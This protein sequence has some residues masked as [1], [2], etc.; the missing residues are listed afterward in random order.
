MTQVP[1]T[2]NGF[3][4]PSVPRLNRK[5]P[6]S[7]PTS[8]RPLS[9][10]SKTPRKAW[11]LPRSRPVC[12][13]AS[14]SSA[15]PPTASSAGR[16]GD[17]HGEAARVRSFLL[18]RAAAMA[19]PGSLKHL[20]KAILACV[21]QPVLP[22]PENVVDA[23][24][25]YIDEHDDVALDRLQDELSAIFEKH[26]K[27]N[28]AA[29]APWIAA[30]RRLLPVLP[31]S[32]R[33][34]SWFDGCNGLLDRTEIDKTV[35]NEVIAALIDLVALIEKHQPNSEADLATKP[36]TDAL[37][38]VSITRLY[39]ALTQGDTSYEYNDKI[40]RRALKSFGKKKP[41]DFFTSVDAYFV[42]KQHRHASLRLLCDFIHDKPPHLHQVLHTSIFSNL[43]TCLQHD[44]STAVVSSALTVLIM[45]LPHMPSSLV[46]HLPTL[47]NVYARLLFWDREMSAAA[48]A[49]PDDAEEPSR[50]WQVCAYDAEI[51]DFSVP[52]LSNYYTILYGLYPINFMDYIRKPQRYLRH[53]N[54]SNPDDIEVQPT[55]IRHRSERFRRCH[56][57]H[58]NFYTRTIDSEKTDNGR[59][60]KSEAAEVLVDCMEL[61]RAADMRDSP[62][63]DAPPPMPGSAADDGLEKEVAEPALLTTTRSRPA[64]W[65]NSQVTST[66]SETSNQAPWTT[67]RR[68]SQS[69]QPSYRFA[70][71][72][73][74]ASPT[75]AA[76]LLRSPSQSQLQD[77]IQSNKVIKSGLH[78]SLANDSVP[79]LALSQ[80]EPATNRPSLRPWAASSPPPGAA[81][82]AS[83]QLAN[84]QRRVLM[85][86]NDL[87]FER[88]VK[89]Q[90]MA[91]MGELRRRQTVEAASEAEAQNIIMMNRNLKSRFEEAKK[92]ERQVRKESERSRALA[93]KW[94]LDLAN[95]VKTLRDES[96]RAAV[97]LG[98]LRRKLGESTGECEK[99]RKLVCDAEVKELNLQQSMQSVEIQRAEVDRLREQ[100]E[101]LTKSGHDEHWR[102]VERQAALDSSA[103]GEVEVEAMRME[104][105]AQKHDGERQRDLVREQVTELQEQLGEAREERA[106]PG[107]NWNLAMESAFAASRAKQAE[108]Q[109][110]YSLLS[111]KYTALQSSLLD[112]QSEA[113]ATA[114]ATASAAA[115][116]AQQEPE[117][118]HQATSPVSRGGPVP[119]EATAHSR[120][121]RPVSYAGVPT[122]AERVSAAEGP[123]S[124]ERH[125]GGR[126]H[127][128]SR[129]EARDKGSKDETSSKA[130]KDKKPSGLRGIRGF[131]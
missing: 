67:R 117:G 80:Q 10:S 122:S 64:S 68:A 36:I 75:M 42:R 31:I 74:Q 11:T 116:R 69:S 95:K 83:N 5:A 112:M 58:S 81:V 34:L 43:L 76:Q 59:W 114:T 118:E 30:L 92:A 13:I 53:A 4:L 88:Y 18:L 104:L 71:D 26:V 57:L 12:L 44:T 131:V 128:R 109:K 7:Q 46:P 120:A 100:V 110:Q 98:A 56:L 73:G 125:F 102:Q 121:P 115:T 29:S 52:Q 25:R 91:H 19:S 28:L 119:A 39:P 130:K 107:S 8:Q 105:S 103:A 61:Y 16:L 93:K 40:V 35:L 45:L 51:D 20:S 84:L 86:E 3:N 32:D 97:E 99:L 50:G 89:Q 54:I 127:S 124:G 90:H 78:Q 6:S 60:I 21:V 123:V 33:I 65:R 77:L 113:A 47:F 106:Q 37:L 72:Q 15:S 111:R 129:K 63:R 22:L 79:S 23:I 14:L 55:E 41:K 24:N 87:S 9:T 48:E 96:K 82:V 62:D 17:I 70:A 85:L 1:T 27:G 49:S 38:A 108:L 101:E 94:E 126:L 66:D 2:C